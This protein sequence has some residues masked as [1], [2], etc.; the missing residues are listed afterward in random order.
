MRC[1]YPAKLS[2]NHELA[3]STLKRLPR[4]VR[5]APIR[6]KHIR[7]PQRRNRG[8]PE[9]VPFGMVSEHHQAFGSRD[10]RPI[11]VGLH[12]VGRGE[13]RSFTHAMHAEEEQIEMECPDS[14]HGDRPYKSIGRG[15]HPTGQHHRLVGT[16]RTEEH[17]GYGHRV[18]H[19]GQ[20]RYGHEPARKLRSC[21]PGRQGHRHP[22]AHQL[23]GPRGD[24]RLLRAVAHRL[25]S[26]T[27]LLCRAG[28]DDRSAT[29][30]LGDQTL[31]RQ[32]LEITAD[33]HV[34]Y[35]EFDDEVADPHAAVQ[36]DPLEDGGL[37]LLCQHV[38]T[39]TAITHTLLV[40]E[41][42]IDL[43]E[44][45]EI[46]VQPMAPR[47]IDPVQRRRI[48]LLA[49]IAG[50]I[51]PTLMGAAPGPVTPAITELA[52]MNYP[53]ARGAIA[54]AG[55]LVLV[56]AGNGNVTAFEETG[57]ARWRTKLRNLPS[58][59][60]MS[61]VHDLVIIVA[62][63]GTDSSVTTSA[64]DPQTGAIRWQRPGNLEVVGDFAVI[65]YQESLISVFDAATME[66][67]W[68]ITDAAA[69]T[70]LPQRQALLIL[71]DSGEVQE[72]DL[73]AGKIVASQQVSLPRGLRP[74]MRVSRERIVIF[75]PIGQ[76]EF[77][78]RL[79]LDA[80]T[81]QPTPNG[82][83][84]ADWRDCGP[85]WCGR[86]RGATRSSIVDK[87]SGRVVR[88]L[89]Q[90]QDAIGTPAGLMTMLYR[91]D[92]T[93]SA[94]S[95]SDPLTGQSRWSLRGWQTVASENF[96]NIS[97]VLVWPTNGRT[98]IAVIRARGVWVLGQ[99]PHEVFGCLLED[100]M[101]LCTTTEGKLGLW[102][103]STPDA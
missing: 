100:R 73:A 41:V 4:R 81:L 45:W 16:A 71:T 67:R 84:W 99:V 68:T 96:N 12:Q 72:R 52:I 26:E 39:I 21:R 85:V 63:R 59:V 23:R 20:L 76:S 8:Y 54:F 48:V 91:T 103:I 29:V 43:G 28:T 98:H 70:A 31:V 55:D 14:C 35:A 86:I 37:S 87:A 44:D 27:W 6:D 18:G 34:G 1:W 30:D 77:E 2:R 101:L 82:V 83:H 9:K 80:T 40:R 15:P 5:K 42:L 33:R 47:P 102:R 24:R 46:P 89:L 49:F 38:L 11:R 36:T 88:A 74:K 7:L 64:I 50:L 62:D 13:A 97:E 92:G 65:T 58:I 22:R 66:P 51:V 90:G 78:E 60:S 93:Y 32:R 61:R 69:H 75:G 17:V 10:K 57:Q 19:D 3:D 56:S 25:R 94:V 53:G 79:W 95:L